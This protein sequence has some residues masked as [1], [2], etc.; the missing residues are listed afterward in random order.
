MPTCGLAQSPPSSQRQRRAGH[1][2]DG[3]SAQRMARE[4]VSL[5]LLDPAQRRT[6]PSL[7][8]V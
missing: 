5:R 2:P 1:V 8:P 7:T 4:C 3:R 6:L